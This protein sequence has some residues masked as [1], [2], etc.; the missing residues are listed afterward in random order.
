MLNAGVRKLLTPGKV[1]FN[2]IFA[3]AND[4]PQVEQGSRILVTL[5]VNKHSDAQINYGTGKRYK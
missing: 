2:S 4:Q 1:K 3:D 5:E